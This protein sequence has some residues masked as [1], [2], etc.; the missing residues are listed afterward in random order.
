MLDDG[1]PRGASAP[2]H[3]IESFRND[4]WP[5]YKTSAGVDADLLAQFEPLEDALRALGVTVWATVDVEAD[6]A[7]AAA[8]TVAE[9]DPRVE[10]V[11]ICTPDKDLA[12]AVVGERVVQLDRRNGTVRVEAGV[13]A[14][15]GVPPASFPDWLALVGAA[16]RVPGSRAGGRSRRRVLARYGIS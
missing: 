5:G 3:V 9:A 10:Q 1:A 12:Q 6:D 11:V 4:L 15:F 14:R 2:D 8:A 16:R 13:V 7:L